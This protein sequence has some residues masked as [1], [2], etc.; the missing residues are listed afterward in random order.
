MFDQALA[1][2]RANHDPFLDGLKAF[3]RIPSISTLSDNHVN[4]SNGAKFVADEL[5]AMGMTEVSIVPGRLDEHPI[6]HA[7]WRGAPGKPT[8]LIY[9][10]YDV[11]PPDPLGEWISPPFDP[12]VRNGKLFARGASDDKGQV[13]ILLKALQGYFKTAGKLPV[14]VIV[15]IE[16]EEESSGEHI[17]RYVREKGKALGAS[18]AI[19]LDTGMFA[20]GMP[21]ITTGLRGL[22]CAEITCRGATSDKHSGNFGGVAP[23]AGTELAKIIA[24]MFTP[25]GNVRIP[26]FYKQVRK[27][28][29]A[30]LKAWAKLPFDEERFRRDTVGAPALI[31]DKRYSVL[32][33]I[34]ARPTL[35]SNG[36]TSGFTDEGFKTVIPATAIAKMSMRLVPDMD[37]DRTAQA[38]QSFVAKLTPRCVTTEVKIISKSPAIVADTS[39][40]FVKTMAEAL[41]ATFK[42]DTVYVRRGGSIPIA[43]TIQSVL[44]VPVILTGFT[45]P[46]CNMHGPNESIDLGNFYSGIEAIGRYFALLGK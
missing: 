27:P 37:P 46:D 14:N 33:R 36:I 1:H 10:H 35:E 8:V 23:N 2:W 9:G 34:Y 41:T 15:L 4:M 5:K 38:F 7:E 11:Q 6:V 32:H 21:T 45:L 29:R 13:Y 19:V 40:P 20:P 25:K 31:G 16:G 18:V 22:I 17:E 24:T 44:S 12:Q 43:G 39:N 26:G 28:T 42:A 30:E 3:L